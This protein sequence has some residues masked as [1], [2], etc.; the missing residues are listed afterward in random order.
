MKKLVIES[1]STNSIKWAGGLKRPPWRLPAL[2]RKIKELISGLEVSFVHVRRTTNGLTDFF[3]KNGV[4]GSN[5]DTFW[6][7]GG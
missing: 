3:A 5:R 7:Q 2:V 1:D 4:D 6:L